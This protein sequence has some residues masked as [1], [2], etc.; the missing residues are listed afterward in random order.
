MVEQNNND[1]GILTTKLGVLHDDVNEIKAAL[2]KLSD[3]ITKLAL[4]EERQSQTTQALER[5]F[6]AIERVETR[7]ASIERAQPEARRMAHW[8]DRALW[9]AA[10]AVAVFVARKVGLIP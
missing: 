3:A 10:A 6:V 8:L 2:S 7:L 9:A 5:A 4:V 1:L